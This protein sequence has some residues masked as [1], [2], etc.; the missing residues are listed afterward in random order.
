MSSS[1]LAAN[2]AATVCKP[3]LEALLKK[4][5]LNTS[6]M[7]VTL[8]FMCFGSLGLM[9]FISKASSRQPCGRSDSITDQSNAKLSFVI[10]LRISR[11][12]SHGQQKLVMLSTIEGQSATWMTWTHPLAPARTFGQDYA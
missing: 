11:P 4:T 3:Q 2:A 12:S 8:A 6:A 1:P 9:S 7:S 10:H 5:S